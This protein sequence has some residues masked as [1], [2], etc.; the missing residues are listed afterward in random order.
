MTASCAPKADNQRDNQLLIEPAKVY[1]TASSVIS[2]C[3]PYHVNLNVR[4]EGPQPRGTTPNLS[5]M[6]GHIIPLRASADLAGGCVYPSFARQIAS[7][8]A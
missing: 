8:L 5:C 2:M 7:L 6:Y 1:V 4:S 3:V